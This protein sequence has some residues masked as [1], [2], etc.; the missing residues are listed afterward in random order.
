MAN[1][2]SCGSAFT[3]G[4]RE[5]TEPC[6]CA[7]LPALARIDPARDCLCPAC[8]ASLVA[9]KTPALPDIATASTDE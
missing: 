4:L 8:L 5:T 3:C 1:C 2:S 9:A 6:W 7:R